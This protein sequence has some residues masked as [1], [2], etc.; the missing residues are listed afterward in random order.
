M[1]PLGRYVVE[2][3]CT[4]TDVYACA[5][6]FQNIDKISKINAPILIAHGNRDEVVPYD[7]GQQLATKLQKDQR[8]LWKF[9]TIDRA[10]HNDIESRHADV[11]HACPVHCS[12]FCSCY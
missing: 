6:I 8:P 12:H 3:V 1:D 7:H 5:D 9:L 10:G 4:A 11:C 2:C